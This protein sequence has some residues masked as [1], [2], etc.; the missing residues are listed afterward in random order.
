[1]ETHPSQG[2]IRNVEGASARLSFLTSSAI[3]D[4]ETKG[5]TPGHV[6][7]LWFIAINEPDNCASSPCKAPDVL[8]NTEAVK[9]D[10]RWAAGSIAKPDGTI[11]LRGEVPY[12]SW[13]RGWFQTGLL[14]PE[15]AE[16]HFVL[17]D[18]GPAIEGREESMTTSYRE[19]CTDESLPPPFPASAKTDGEPG[20]NQCALVQDAIFIQDNS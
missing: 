5:L 6:Y 11:T 1:V 3:A 20:P 18:H 10:V 12:G 14:E 13:D 17:N 19:G 16:V 2:E 8:V 15:V 9:A 4:F 7:T